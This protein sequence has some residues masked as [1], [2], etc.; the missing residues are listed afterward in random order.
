MKLT[1]KFNSNL[2]KMN[3][4]HH[5]KLRTQRLLVEFFGILTENPSSVNTLTDGRNPLF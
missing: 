1:V 4:S 3:I 2:S 5:L